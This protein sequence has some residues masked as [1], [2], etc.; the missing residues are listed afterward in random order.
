MPTQM[1]AGWIDRIERG[2]DW[3]FVRLRLP[4]RAE[5]PG[6]QVAERVWTAMQ[7]HMQRRVVLELDELPILRSELIRELILLYRRI[8]SNGGMLRLAGV[9]D[10]NQHV[11]ELCRLGERF[12]RYRDRHDAVMATNSLSHGNTN[13]R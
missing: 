12:P 5:S 10:D 4:D 13:P 7:Y 6:C 3:L 1:A 9:S 11:L 8:Q 2:P